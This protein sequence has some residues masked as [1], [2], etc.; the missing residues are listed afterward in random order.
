MWEWLREFLGMREA[1]RERMRQHELDLKTCRACE[2]LQA[3]LVRSH[4]REQQ[5]IDLLDNI[6]NKPEPELTPFI[7]QSPIATS[8][9]VPWS[10]KRQ[11]LEQKDRRRAVKEVS[12]VKPITLASLDDELEELRKKSDAQ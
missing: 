8:S 10:V 4:S 1:E 3:E 9:K 6:N 7:S 5:L 11:Q 2:A 12:G